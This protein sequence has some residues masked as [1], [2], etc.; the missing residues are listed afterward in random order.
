MKQ[1]IP[2]NTLLLQ[3]T[4]HMMDSGKRN[5]YQILVF[6]SCSNGHAVNE[7]PQICH[8]A[9]RQSENKIESTETYR[10]RQ[11]SHQLVLQ[12]QLQWYFFQTHRGL[13]QLIQTIS[14]KMIGSTSA[15]SFSL[16]TAKSFVNI[17]Y[18]NIHKSRCHTLK[19]SLQPEAAQLSRVLLH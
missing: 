1:N 2:L 11:E 4:G 6:L 15:S 19:V 17:H 7:T 8:T 12:C 3:N 14:T 16:A 9:R 13:S 18:M 5:L 10:N